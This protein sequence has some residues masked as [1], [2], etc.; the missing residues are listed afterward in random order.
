[1]R[2]RQLAEM[3]AG[4]DQNAEIF[5]AFY[6]KEEAE[7]HIQENL[8][9]GDEFPLTDDQWQDIILQID[10]EDGIFQELSDS[11]AYHCESM[12]NKIQKE[13][14]SNVSSQ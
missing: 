14:V 9:E 5:V 8:N 2:I 4:M 13:R 11:F 1:M 6:T 3:L 12:F 10:H 7:E